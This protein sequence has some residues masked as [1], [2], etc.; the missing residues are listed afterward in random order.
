MN[1]TLN[2]IIRFGTFLG[3]AF[4]SVVVGVGT[5]TIA[6]NA[7]PVKP[8]ALPGVSSIQT[9]IEKSASMKALPASLVPL[10][11]GEAKSMF[12]GGSCQ[13]GG[14]GSSSVANACSLGDLKATT[15]VVLYGDS[16]SLEWA[17]AFNSLGI[18]DHFKVLLFARNGCPYAD[19]KIKDWEGS[20]DTGCLPFRHNVIEAVNALKPSP[21]LVVLSGETDTSV[22][23]ASWTSGIQKTIAQFDQT[24]FP[25]DVIFGEAD[26]ASPP[27]A[28]LARYA[29]NITKCS[30][31][32]KAGLGYQEYPQVASAVTSVHAGLINT[33]SLFCY[34]G[35]CPDVIADTLVHSDSWHI[36][37][38]FATLTTQ[39]L[40]SLIGC[41]IDQFGSIV[42]QSRVLLESLL[43]GSNSSETKIACANSVTTNGI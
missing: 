30:T 5:S 4:A 6:A 31:S 23:V 40:S 41:T 11:S 17:P 24:K 36:D 19:V 3:L 12:W 39:G 32:V 2:K 18:K 26:A 21:S 35:K 22:P 7:S 38:S 1:S 9:A 27:D 16:F 43:T 13:V 14:P 34:H 33:S 10:L 20:V 42:P 15:T 37:Q 25:V 29:S 8:V 28:C